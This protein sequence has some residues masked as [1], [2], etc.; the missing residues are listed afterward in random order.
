MRRSGARDTISITAAMA[1]GPAIAG[2]ASGTMN[3]SPSTGSPK[4]PS[5]WRKIIRSAIRNR[6]TPPAMDSEEPD[7]PEHAEDRPSEEREHEQH[8]VGDA[9]FAQDHARA[10]RPPDISHQGNEQ[11]NVADRVHDQQQDHDGRD[12]GGIHARAPLYAQ[13]MR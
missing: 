2:M 7:R 10:P 5:G 9:A 3:G 11:R 1:A 8:G 12:E 13:I 4:M 6:I